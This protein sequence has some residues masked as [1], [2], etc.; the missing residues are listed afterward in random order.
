MAIDVQTD[1]VAEAI[2]RLHERRRQLLDWVQTEETSRE[3]AHEWK[4]AVLRGRLQEIEYALEL[5]EP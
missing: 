4:A 3:G 5:L 2:H 1:R